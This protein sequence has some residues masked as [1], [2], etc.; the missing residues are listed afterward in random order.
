MRSGGGIVQGSKNSGGTTFLNE[1]A[2]DLVVEVFDRSPLD[3]FAD[4]LFLLSFEGKLDKDLLEFFVDVVDA[5]LFK[6]VV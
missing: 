5:Q 6:A 3:L 2:H 4:V 1:V